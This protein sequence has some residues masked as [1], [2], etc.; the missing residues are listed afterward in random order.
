[1]GILSVLLFCIENDL[2]KNWQIRLQTQA[3][4]ELSF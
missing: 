1:M 4:S 3:I 2:M